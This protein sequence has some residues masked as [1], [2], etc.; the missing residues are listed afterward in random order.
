MGKG[1]AFL[2]NHL[3]RRSISYPPVAVLW[4][5]A[6]YEDYTGRSDQFMTYPRRMG[7]DLN[8]LQSGSFVQ[9]S[10]RDGLKFLQ[11]WLFFG[12]LT[13]ALGNESGVILR[14]WVEGYESD[15]PGPKKM[16][17][18]HLGKYLDVFSQRLRDVRKK[19][20]WQHWKTIFSICITVAEA[21][22]TTFDRETQTPDFSDEPHSM[23]IIWSI[24]TLGQMLST[25][26]IK[27][28]GIDDET[29]KHWPDSMLIHRRLRRLGFCPSVT[30]RL[31]S[32]LAMDTI[33]T[34]SLM[35]W[36]RPM[37]RYAVSKDQ[38]ENGDPNQR[39]EIWDCM[40]RVSG[41]HRN[42]NPIKCDLDNI[43]DALYRSSHVNTSCSCVDTDCQCTNAKCQCAASEQKCTNSECAC[44]YSACKCTASECKCR[45]SQCCRADSIGCCAAHGDAE[46]DEMN[47]SDDTVSLVQDLWTT[48]NCINEIC[49]N[50]MDA[51]DDCGFI[52]P[53]VE[54]VVS[55]LDQE[56]VPVFFIR[57]ALDTSGRL[58]LSV[59]VAPANSVEKYVA[60]S[61][62]WAD[63]LGNKQGNKL[64]RCQIARIA[65][66]LRE[67]T[68]EDSPAFWIDTFG[69]PRALNDR[70]KALKL[71]N[72]TYRLAELTVVL[73][74]DL[75]HFSSHRA[76]YTRLDE[77]NIEI[78]E[79]IRM[80]IVVELLFRI[81][82]TSWTA[83]LWTLP[84]GQL[85]PRLYFQF[86]DGAVELGNIYAELKRWP[87]IG[88]TFVEDIRS[89]LVRLRPLLR[90]QERLGIPPEDPA[91]RAWPT[92]SLDGQF[93][94]MMHAIEW[95]D[96]S[97]KEDEAICLAI[98]LGLDVSK[99][100]EADDAHKLR[101]LLEQINPLP[102]DLMFTHGPR[103]T[104]FPWRWAPQCLLGYKDKYNFVPAA[105]PRTPMGRMTPAGLRVR[106]DGF[107]LNL[108]NG[109]P[110]SQYLGF[111]CFPVDEEG[112]VKEGPDDI[113]TVFGMSLDTF[114]PMDPARTNELNWKSSW[115]AEAAAAGV[116]WLH[117]LVGFKG[118]HGPAVI[119]T[120][121]MIG[122]VVFMRRAAAGVIY[123]I[124]LETVIIYEIDC[125]KHPGVKPTLTG[126]RLPPTT[127]VI[128]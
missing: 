70:K 121:G 91:M 78:A 58:H 124:P 4:T 113:S 107:M 125:E 5:G 116:V 62:V 11:S 36:H 118:F 79:Q 59:E 46:I 52:G 98:Q 127:F 27:R 106:Y 9:H 32:L 126:A 96:T 85:S 63:G 57:K 123:G 41:R 95:R 87:F 82:C 67:L 44:P 73:A 128:G 10:Q 53:S 2:L 33:T 93:I 108:E 68:E 23:C 40:Y 61:H 64:P 60:I 34:L 26:A 111:V 37:S 7:F 56:I 94:A 38:L 84:E 66:L 83:R 74:A 21:F 47:G 104:T 19:P 110:D 51:E 65:F 45:R 55:I 69:I 112:R 72:A 43:D 17:S 14:F 102:A 1:G 90:Q 86:S 30:A 39:D 109:I 119:D 20:P 105:H 24:L 114:K 97:W 75:Q 99:I 54:E 15:A 31:M 117:I 103:M 88:T 100:T 120:P 81:L 25:V 89:F 77:I 35:Y 50:C 28:Y 12:L 71:M 122:L 16:M 49:L 18:P 6:Q 29:V 115:T 13:E 76:L 3:P 22:D 8:E 101:A 80:G 42:C 92:G 48:C